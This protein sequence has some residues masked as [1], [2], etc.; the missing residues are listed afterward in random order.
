[1]FRSSNKRTNVY[2]V[3]RSAKEKRIAETSALRAQMQVAA[4][5]VVKCEKL[6][7]EAL[8]SGSVEDYTGAKSAARDAE[9]RKEFFRLKIEDLEGTPLF[10]EKQI[11]EYADEIKKGY[12]EKKESRMKD[13]A[14]LIRKAKDI[15]HQQIDD[16]NRANEALAALD[17]KRKYPVKIEDL[18]L[19]GMRN[20]IDGL[21]RTGSIKSYWENQK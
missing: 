14:E 15:N 13:M 1:M 21:E 19:F 18:E 20:G 8:E 17:E 9:D 16:L 5:E 2:D 6:A 12:A 11:Q 3:I 4:G 7:R 10:S